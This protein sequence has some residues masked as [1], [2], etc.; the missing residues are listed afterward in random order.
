MDTSK[1]VPTAT[2]ELRTQCSS[3]FVGIRKGYMLIFIIDA[4]SPAELDELSGTL[5]SL[6]FF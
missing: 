2:Y 4:S 5:V 3:Y 6:R 1:T